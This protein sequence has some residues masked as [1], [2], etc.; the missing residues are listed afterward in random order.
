MYWPEI[1]GPFASILALATPATT[2]PY[3]QLPFTLLSLIKLEIISFL[4]QSP[5]SFIHQSP[6]Q[7]LPLQS[8]CLTHVFMISSC[9]EYQSFTAATVC[10]SHQNGILGPRL[11]REF[12]ADN[13]WI[14]SCL[15]LRLLSILHFHH[16]PTPSR[17]RRATGGTA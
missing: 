1:V 16:R 17:D 11:T 2:A 12:L 8:P 3:S 9:F 5:A 14:G 13:L 10:L 15:R 4:H 6:G 7:E